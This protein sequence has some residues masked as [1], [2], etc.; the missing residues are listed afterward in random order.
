MSQSSQFRRHLA[1]CFVLVLVA[2]PTAMAAPASAAPGHHRASG[3]GCG[4]ATW[5]PSDY[6]PRP[7]QRQV[8][9]DCLSISASDVPGQFGHAVLFSF[10][11]A[12]YADGNLITL[13]S[14]VVS[15]DPEAGEHILEASGLGV[16]G[17]RYYIFIRD[18]GGELDEFYVGPC[19]SSL[20]GWCSSAGAFEIRNV[21][22]EPGNNSA[23]AAS[24]NHACSELSC[25]F[26][27]SGSSDS[28]GSIASYDWDLGDG[29]TAN[30]VTTSHT[31]PAAGTYSVTL[32]VTDDQGATSSTSQDIAVSSSA[33]TLSAT[34]ERR[35]NTGKVELYWAGAT[36]QD[37]DVYRNETLIGTTANDGSYTDSIVSPSGSY[38]YKICEVASATC[39][40]DATV[41]F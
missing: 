19:G 32:T 16:T 4:F 30:G 33:I 36:S 15:D 23:P 1:V 37:I 12:G 3:V 34:G 21:T 31:Y 35:G 18:T 8:A 6:P 24:F 41:D 13:D 29:T 25:S 28:D 9:T 27:A 2:F 14:V 26:D 17:Q 5:D 38:T 20:G 11:T 22:T 10:E 40:N 39:S 7:W